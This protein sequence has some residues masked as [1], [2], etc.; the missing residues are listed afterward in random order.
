MLILSKKKIKR[1]LLKRNQSRKINNSRKKHIH[2]GGKKRKT[3]KKLNKQTNLR[4][5]TLR[6]KK[7]GGIKGLSEYPTDYKDAINTYF[8]SITNAG[9]GAVSTSQQDVIEKI[10]NDINSNKGYL[11]DLTRYF[12]LITTLNNPNNPD[13]TVIRKQIINILEYIYSLN[14]SISSSQD[15]GFNILEVTMD[16]KIRETELKITNTFA[17][18]IKKFSELEKKKQNIKDLQQSKDQSKPIFQSSDIDIFTIDDIYNAIVSL[19]N[20]LYSNITELQKYYTNYIYVG[21]FQ[22]SLLSKLNVNPDSNSSDA[23]NATCVDL[24]M[25]VIGLQNLSIAVGN[26]K[27]LPSTLITKMN[28]YYKSQQTEYINSWNKTIDD[29]LA[30]VKKNIIKKEKVVGNTTISIVNI[31]SALLEMKKKDSEEFDKDSIIINVS[32]NGFNSVNLNS[33]ILT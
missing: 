30:F 28:D 4:N 19:F 11:D 7:R 9:T 10:V 31:I 24:Q 2:N 29:I 33:N 6:K 17:E 12:R 25:I 23:L 3:Y 14:P 5:K 27:V 1:L 8:T 13:E 20:A 18:I 21:E 16:K 15:F 26:P 22:G 32:T